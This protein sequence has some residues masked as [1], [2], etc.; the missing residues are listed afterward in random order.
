ME[1]EKIKLR[2]PDCKIIIQ[3]NPKLVQE[4]YIQCP[5]PL[6]QKIFKNPLKND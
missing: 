4:N 3:I 1:E 2:C 6:C 5:N